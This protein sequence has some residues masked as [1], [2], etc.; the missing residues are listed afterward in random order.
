MRYNDHVKGVCSVSVRGERGLIQSKLADFPACIV[1]LVVEITFHSLE[2]IYIIKL[3]VGR[4]I[5]L[6]HQEM[7]KIC[8]LK[9]SSS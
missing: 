5:V 8:K 6:T 2:N 9:D 4:R 3:D 1:K 7:V